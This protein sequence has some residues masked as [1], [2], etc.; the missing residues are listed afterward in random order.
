MSPRDLVR[1]AV[2]GVGALAGASSFLL[3]G[4][5]SSAAADDATL[6]IE[7]AQGTVDDGVLRLITNRACPPDARN[8]LVQ[9][10]GGRFPENSNAIGNTELAGF[11]PP[12]AGEGLVIP[13][14]GSWA[15]TADANGYHDDLDGTA[16]MTLVCLSDDSERILSRVTGEVRF[17]RSGSGPVR[18]EQVGGA[19]LDSGLP[20]KAAD[21]PNNGT[22]VYRPDLPPGSPG[23][24]PAGS[25]N[26][27]VSSDGEATSGA[28]AGST[29]SDGTSGSNSG[30]HLGDAE[31]SASARGAKADSKT[32]LLIGGGLLLAAAGG[33]YLVYGRAR[34]ELSR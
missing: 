29:D 11:F 30:E 23:G 13:M 4:T 5:T 22:Y 34:R 8:F 2:A 17:F 9:I 27:V 26:S 28:A 7:P 15:V 21:L 25:G 32:P 19:H 10:S 24:P 20:Y 16:T 3:L 33:G 31:L 12:K 6:A 1:R 18:Y 14:L